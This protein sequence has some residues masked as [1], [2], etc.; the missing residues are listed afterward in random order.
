MKNKILCSK[1]LK[2]LIDNKN[3]N[4]QMSTDCIYIIYKFQKKS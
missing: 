2:S 4:H 1:D 3:Q